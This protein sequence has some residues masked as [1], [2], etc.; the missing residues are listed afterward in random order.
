MRGWRRNVPRYRDPRLGL[1]RDLLDI[2]QAGGAQVKSPAVRTG[3]GM[4][5]IACAVLAVAQAGLGHA[6]DLAIQS[7]LI[8]FASRPIGG[9]EVLRRARG[10][11][12]LP[13][14]GH[15]G[16]GPLI[17]QV[18]VVYLDPP[19]AAVGDVDVVVRIR[20]NAVRRVEL[21][22]AAAVRPQ[23][24][25]P[26]SAGRDLDHPRIAITVGDEDVAVRVPGH[27]RRP[28]EFSY[29][30]HRMLR[31]VGQPGVAGP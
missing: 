30:A 22:A 6:D 10:D 27:I 12:E 9:E 13:G 4:D 8:D 24:L 14:H 26:L 25:E 18:V 28:V 15:P 3:D 31:P 11:T 19:V 7:Q 21:I 17:A 29:L 2:P 23:L 16:D 5:E 20:G 1:D